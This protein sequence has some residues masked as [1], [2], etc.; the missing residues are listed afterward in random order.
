MMK[1]HK[2][3]QEDEKGRK[4]TEEEEVYST[5]TTKTIIRK[6]S[7]ITPANPSGTPAKTPAK[8]TGS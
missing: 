1:L 5:K 6:K 3:S 8:K 4:E 7:G 2:L